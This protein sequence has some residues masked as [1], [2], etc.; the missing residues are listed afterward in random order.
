MRDSHAGPGCRSPLAIGPAFGI[1]VRAG[2]KTSSVTHLRWKE[3]GGN[4]AA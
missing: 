4:E 2:E 1:V 3:S